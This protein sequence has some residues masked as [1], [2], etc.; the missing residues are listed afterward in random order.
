MAVA[1]VFD[2]LI[3]K[4]RYRDARSIEQ[5]YVIIKAGA[6]SQFDPEV[7]AAFIMARPQIE[8]VVKKKVYHM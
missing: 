2:A 7:A 3:S 4:R 5:A 6:G 1:D 8:Q